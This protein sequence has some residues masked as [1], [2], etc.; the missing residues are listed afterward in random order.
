MIFAPLFCFDYGC[1]DNDYF[2]RRDSNE[3]YSYH[4]CYFAD[5][6]TNLSS[7]KEI[8]KNIVLYGHN[9]FDD[10]KYFAQLL[11]YKDWEHLINY[12]YIYFAT[13][14]GVKTYRIY[15]AFYTF[16]NFYYINPNPSKEEFDYVL[17]E[18]KKRSLY[19]IDVP[20]SYEDNIIT[21]STCCYK[22]KTSWG[23]SRNDQRFVIQAV[24][25]KQGNNEYNIPTIN[26]SPKEPYVND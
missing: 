17:N 2:L 9:I 16:T 1:K 21:L 7:E 8:S 14:N 24:E 10:N 11:K 4:G 15:C 19:N 5:F 25:I 23:S 12:P 13:E 26:P 20:V 18:A 3:N 22:Y 6:R